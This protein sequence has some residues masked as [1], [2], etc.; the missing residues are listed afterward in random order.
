MKISINNYARILYEALEETKQDDIAV[1][2]ENFVKLLSRN[3]H[4]RYSKRIIT[5]FEELYN[6]KNGIVKAEVISKENL[7]DSAIKKIKVFFKEKSWV[8]EVELTNKINPEMIGGIILKT[9]NEMIDKSID[10]KLAE[11]N[12]HLLA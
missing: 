5:G 4:L 11:L 3:N 8:K 2:I 7:D 9:T 10:G 12:K 6:K 1:V